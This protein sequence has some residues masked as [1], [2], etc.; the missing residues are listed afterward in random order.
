MER[1][2]EAR[3]HEHF[4]TTRDRFRYKVV[5]QLRAVATTSSRHNL[6]TINFFVAAVQTGFGPFI[7]VILTERREFHVR[8][9]VHRVSS[10]RNIHANG[11]PWELLNGGATMYYAARI[12]LTNRAFLTEDGPIHPAP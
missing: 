12:F 9:C 3:S 4:A 10:N 8:L 5:M 6:D 7:A 11:E 2:R 1:D